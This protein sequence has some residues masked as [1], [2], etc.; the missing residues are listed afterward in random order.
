MTL[1]LETVSHAKPAKGLSH[2]LSAEKLSRAFDGVPQFRELRLHFNSTEGAPL[3]KAIPG[4]R[5]HQ[6]H[7]AE[8]GKLDAYRRIL[9][10]R[11][12]EAEGWSLTLDCVP[13]TRK[14][15]V[16]R[17]MLE[18]AL[19]AV[20]EWLTA[21]RPDSWYIGHRHVQLGVSEI[22]DELAIRVT[23][24]DRIEQQ[25]EFLRETLTQ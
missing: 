25:E 8:A 10:C 23:H 6:L 18:R 12:V 20:R 24:N 7:G 22:L 3:G 13:S 1:L 19:P 9:E 2:P 16:A 4:D 21:S 15:V 11:W 5:A 17:E 14:S